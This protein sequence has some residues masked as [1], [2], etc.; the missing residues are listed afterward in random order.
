MLGIA[1]LIG[2]TGALALDGFSWG[3][4][5]EVSAR[6]GIDKATTEQVLADLQ[7]SEW[8]L[9]FYLMTVA[10]ILGF[11]VLALGAWRTGL[12]PAWAAGALTVGAI[13]VGPRGRDQVER[14]LHRGVRRPAR[15]HRR[16]RVRP[17]RATPQAA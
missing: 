7:N 4:V 17:Q 6:P 12:V 8:G 2:L 9:Q 5:G 16:V 3:I 1:G 14:L 11:L 10:W 13:A 15:R